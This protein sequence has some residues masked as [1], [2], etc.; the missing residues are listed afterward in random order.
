MLSEESAG[1]FFISNPSALNPMGI[2]M[3]GQASSVAGSN[4]FHQSIVRILVTP[5]PTAAN[6]GC[7][8]GKHLRARNQQII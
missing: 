1:V 2:Q 3:T 8:E 5:S 7:I 6:A 4:D